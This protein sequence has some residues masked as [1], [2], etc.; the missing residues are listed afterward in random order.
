MASPSRVGLTKR[1]DNVIVYTTEPPYSLAWYG[2]YETAVSI[3]GE[4]WRI[5]ESYETLEE[6]VKGH[7]KFSKMSKEELMAYKYIR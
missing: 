7:Y 3:D 4:R 5:A 6:A 2:E 1:D